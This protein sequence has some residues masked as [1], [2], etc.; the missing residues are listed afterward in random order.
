MTAQTFPPEALLTECK[1]CGQETLRWQGVE[2]DRE[3]KSILTLTE[4]ALW[5]LEHG[6]VEHECS[7]DL[8]AENAERAAEEATPRGIAEALR[9]LDEVVR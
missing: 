6:H 3:L 5:T 8:I 4:E 2:Y 1:T 9:E 7:P